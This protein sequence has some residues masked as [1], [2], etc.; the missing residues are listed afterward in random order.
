MLHGGGDYLRD[1]I[2]G[3]DML[4]GGRGADTLYGGAGND[5]L[6]GGAG[7]DVLRGELR[8]GARQARFGGQHTREARRLLR[9]GQLG[10]GREHLKRERTVG[11]GSGVYGAEPQ[12][13]VEQ[14][15]RAHQQ[16]HGDR[17]LCDDQAASHPV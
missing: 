15:P 17:H 14:Q 11:V 5:A 7:Y 10:V 13:R 4:S 6:I 9:F 1:I 16:H 2:A 8:R 12:E 3:N